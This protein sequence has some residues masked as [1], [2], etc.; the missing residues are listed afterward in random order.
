MHPKR[1]FLRLHSKTF[2]L[3]KIAQVQVIVLFLLQ[4]ADD[5]FL[6]NLEDNDSDEKEFVVNQELQH[7]H[8]WL[9]SY[10]KELH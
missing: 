8:D 1:C 5:T 10:V 4:Y 3:I 7:A 6:C 9:I 2:F